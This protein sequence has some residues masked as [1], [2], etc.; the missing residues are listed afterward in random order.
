MENNK[1]IETLLSRIIA[2]REERDWKQFH[3]PKDMALSL[4]LESSE[5]MEH[6]QW[7]NKEEI[8][9]YVVSHKEHIG[10]ELADV[11]SWVLLMSHDLDIDV[12]DALDKKI[13]KNEK[14]YPV[15]KAK[16]RHTKYDQL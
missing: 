15:E 3:N 4:V 12:F 9:A 16:G 14:K 5:V 6:F 13:S 8:E 2:F 11:L 10:E 1:K 7:K